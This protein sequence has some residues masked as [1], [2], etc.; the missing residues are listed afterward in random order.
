MNIPHL[1]A[2][3]PGT[4]ERIHLNN[5]GAALMPLPVVDAVRKYLDLESRIGGYEAY[6]AR[7]QAIEGVYQSLANLLGARSRNI[8]LTENATVS[9]AQALSCIPFRKGEVILTTR[10]DYASSQI[11]FLSLQKRFGVRIIRAPDR[12]AGGVDVAAMA[13]LI[14]KYR[15]KLVSVTHIP[16][17]SGLIQDVHTIGAVCKSEQVLYLVDACQSIGQIPIDVHSLQCDF[18]AASARKFLRGPRGAGFLYIS[19][20]VLDSG[21][22]P[23]FLDMRGA[24]WVEE[25]AYRPVLD[26]R[27]FENW[28]F[29]WALVLGMGEAADYAMNVGIEAIWSRTS[30]LS[31]TLREALQKMGRL[32]VLDRGAELSGIISV[33]VEGWDPANLVAAFRRQGINTS[34]QVR[35]SAVIDYD[36]KGVKASWRISPHYYNTEEELDRFIDA[37]KTLI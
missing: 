6:H 33:S 26:A 18:L 35:T 20:R 4:A 19:D 9:I 1:R 28:E 31:A 15:P 11:Q 12:A 2:D 25:E 10:N 8:A 14:T 7:Q 24:D 3:T 17:N 13:E 23:M 21:Y 22:E 32:R 36:Q 16:T 34:A 29:S 37:L 5:A 27:R 30:A